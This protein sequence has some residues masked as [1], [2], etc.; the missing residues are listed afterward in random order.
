MR[1]THGARGLDGVWWGSRLHA[2]GEG[3]GG[4]ESS[5]EWAAETAKGPQGRRKLIKTSCWEKGRPGA[6]DRE[7]GRERVR[8]LAR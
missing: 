2:A 5:G 1:G 7:Q 8:E 6:G 4:D 3:V